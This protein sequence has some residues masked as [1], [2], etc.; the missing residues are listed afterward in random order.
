MRHSNSLRTIHEP[1]VPISPMQVNA[2]NQELELF[3]FY[4][5]EVTGRY[6]NSLNQSL[7]TIHI[8]Q[9]ARHHP[10]I[11]RA[12]NAVAA[13]T[14]WNNIRLTLGNMESMSSMNAA[15]T[16]VQDRMRYLYTIG[17]R[18]YALS[19]EHVIQMTQLAQRCRTLSFDDKCV[20]L[21]TNMLFMI[22][23]IN[24]NERLDSLSHFANG[25]NLIEQ[26]N[27]WQE[28]RPPSLP[29]PGSIDTNLNGAIIP[30]MPLLLFYVQT[31]GVT[32][33]VSTPVPSQERVW[34]WK[35]A[36]VS[37]QKQ[38]ICSPM[39]AYLELELIWIGTCGVIQ[40]VPLVASLREN[41]DIA[42]CR[43]EMKMYAENWKTRFDKFQHSKSLPSV[44]KSESGFMIIINMKYILISVMLQADIANLETSWDAFEP[45]FETIICLLESFLCRHA[46]VEEPYSQNR[47]ET[48]QKKKTDCSSSSPSLPN[49]L[50]CRCL[51]LFYVA[52][53]CRHPGLRRRVI[54]LL[55]EQRRRENVFGHKS[56]ISYLLG[57]AITIMEY[58]E[59][60][61]SNKEEMSY[62]RQR[63]RDV[64]CN[65]VP[66][67][68]IC[69][70][71][72]VH[73]FKFRDYQASNPEI[74]LR[75]VGEMMHN[76]PGRIV[77][78]VG[79]DYGC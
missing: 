41:E 21:A 17:L 51:P 68:F 35:N 53:I 69:L 79:L 37:L 12:C 70:G 22:C 32:L 6:K 26:W 2:T 10:C 75:T 25:V 23:S 40:R 76:R 56:D 64:G 28:L 31:D 7:W 58:E 47:T 52:K 44:N 65:C 42:G 78:M 74:E 61:W 60:V 48:T 45:Q 8:L 29:S 30:I 67:R 20:I 46:M 77:S 9:G 34:K 18:Q 33:E 24:G 73:E 19:L 49:F 13:M 4:R 63:Q 14:Q 15:R 11:W 50:P 55:W 39:A 66:G 27:L 1:H 16:T 57:G 72:R 43:I 71:H 5:T 62:E 3:Y 59:S 38:L 54:A 36:L